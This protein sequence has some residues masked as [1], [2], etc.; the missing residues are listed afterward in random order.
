MAAH[1]IHLASSGRNE[2]LSQVRVCGSR[3]RLWLGC[4]VYQRT[5]A[6]VARVN[7]QPT[8]TRTHEYS[9]RT[10]KQFGP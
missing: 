7:E 8:K 9:S 1:F 5:C 2:V 6:Q 3:V 10:N 4:V